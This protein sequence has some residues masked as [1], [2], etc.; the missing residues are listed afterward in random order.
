DGVNAY[1][2]EVLRHPEQLPEAFNILGI[3]PGKWTPEMVI[4]R[5]QGLKGNV[6]QELNIGRAVAKAGADVVEDLMWFH[7]KDPDLRLDSTI[8][9]EMLAKDILGLYNA[10]HRPVAFQ[11]DHPGLSRATSGHGGEHEG[12]NNWVVSGART[13]SGLPL[14]AND[15]HRAIAV[16]SLRY[17]VH[18]VAPGW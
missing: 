8:T 15:P 6:N 18:L 4:S 10:T 11:S 1:I 13:A 16:P 2:G 7:P 3:K 12:S 9:S 5:H 17:M 14:L